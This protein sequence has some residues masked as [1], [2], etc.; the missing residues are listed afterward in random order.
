MVTF[1]AVTKYPVSQV[2]STKSLSYN[3]GR[4]LKLTNAN[5][6]VGGSFLHLGG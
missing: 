3:K 5:I 6:R 2:P 4:T 1:T